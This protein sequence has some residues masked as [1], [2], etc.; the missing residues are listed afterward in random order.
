MR[1][2][3][4]KQDDKR[5]PLSPARRERA[6]TAKGPRNA[7]AESEMHQWWRD[8]RVAMVAPKGSSA[9]PLRVIFPGWSIVAL[10][11]S[12]GDSSEDNQAPAIGSPAGYGKE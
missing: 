8:R 10:V 5:E 7:P 9:G 2:A 12:I 11:N 6:A 4:S 1:P 3:G